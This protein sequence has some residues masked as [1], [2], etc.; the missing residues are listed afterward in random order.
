MSC[1]IIVEL[2]VADDKLERSPPMLLAHSSAMLVRESRTSSLL[3]AH[4]KSQC[5]AMRL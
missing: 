1:A 4:T 5:R 2:V 3:G